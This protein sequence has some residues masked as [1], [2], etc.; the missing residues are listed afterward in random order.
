[1]HPPGQVRSF[2][3]RPTPSRVGSE[4][5]KVCPGAFAVKRSIY[6]QPTQNVLNP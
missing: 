6:L 3:K 5:V 2:Q 1:M 4:S